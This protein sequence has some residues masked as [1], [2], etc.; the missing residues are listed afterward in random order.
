MK[1]DQ[2]P[3]YD[4]VVIGGGSAGI[5]ATIQAA[6]LGAKTLLIEKSAGLGGTTTNGGVNFPGLFHAWGNQIISGIGWSLVKKSVEEA[7]GKLPNFETTP[8]YHHLQQVRINIPLY[9]AI[10]DEAI[11]ES[12]A[13]ILFHTM[14]GSIQDDKMNSSKKVLEICGKTGFQK[15]ITDTIVDCS[16]DGNA[17][18]LAGYP[19]MKSDAQQPST[20]S[21]QMSGYEINS[22]NMEKLNQNFKTWVEEG[23][24]KFIDA[25]WNANGPNVGGFLRNQGAN[26]NHLTDIDGFSSEGRSKL[27]LEGRASILRMFRFLKTQ[28]GFSHLK[29]DWLSPECGVRD[30][31]RIE[32]E[33]TITAD[34][35]ISGKVWEDSL[36]YSYYPIDL[37]THGDG[38]L[39]KRDLVEG[40][41]PTVSMRALIPKGASN[42]LVA[43]RCLSSDREAHSA[44]RVQG[45]C[46]ATGQVAGAVA[47]LCATEGKK[48]QELNLATIK[49]SLKSHGAI[50]PTEGE[51]QKNCLD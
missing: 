19:M 12:G 43:G 33:M 36:C 11:L 38:G 49:A 10:C 26:A 14:V 25:S 47:A 7:G 2:P 34:D 50:V 5:C 13:E 8:K 4:V 31:R 44:L 46:M 32:G 42:F 22:L 29:I 9:M 39:D 17:A 23:N 6:K 21:C 51:F 30:T 3:E 35:Y 15:I 20:Y 41:Y 1:H 28:D 37:H 48:I 24:G 18:Y 27:E 16:A 40:V 45:T